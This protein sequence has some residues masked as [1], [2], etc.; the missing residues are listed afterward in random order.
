MPHFY[1]S[2]QLVDEEISPDGLVA[3]TRYLKEFQQVLMFTCGILLNQCEAKAMALMASIAS[4][5]NQSNEEGSDDYLWTALNCIKES[6]NELGTF[7]KELHVS[8]FA[9]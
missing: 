1:L 6:E 3:D 8:W 4:E 9:S 5:I 2:C 7:G